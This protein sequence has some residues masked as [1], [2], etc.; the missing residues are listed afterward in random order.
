MWCSFALCGFSLF[1]RD[2]LPKGVE[3]IL[4]VARLGEKRDGPGLQGIGRHRQVIMGR[5]KNDWDWPLGP[6]PANTSFTYMGS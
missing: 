6:N 3:Q 2:G 1:T 5:D 4:V